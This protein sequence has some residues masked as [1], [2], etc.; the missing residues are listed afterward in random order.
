MVSFL[1]IPARYLAADQ[2]TPFLDWLKR[3]PVDHG[4]KRQLLHA[5]FAKMNQ[6]ATKADY[7]AGGL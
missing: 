2:K 4:V 6:S 3:I 5:W 7:E 1:D